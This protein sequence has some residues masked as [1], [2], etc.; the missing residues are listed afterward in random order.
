M[1]SNLLQPNLPYFDKSILIQSFIESKILWSDLKLISPHWSLFTS[2]M[3]S[4]LS[5]CSLWLSIFWLRILLSL[6]FSNQNSSFSSHYFFFTFLQSFCA[7]IRIQEA[8]CTQCKC[9][10]SLS[11]LLLR[12]H[13]IAKRNLQQSQREQFCGGRCGFLKGYPEALMKAFY[14]LVILYFSRTFFALTCPKKH[15]RMWLYL[16]LPAPCCPIFPYFSL[17]VW[18]ILCCQTLCLCVLCMFSW[19]SISLSLALG[20]LKSQINSAPSNG[21]PV[22]RGSQMNHELHRQRHLLRSSWGFA[23]S[24]S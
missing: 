22:V 23:V 4:T 19:N 16:P 17:L 5:L 12:N 8:A 20:I 7:T 14:W 10:Q 15:F 18:K 9:C 13:Y 1:C 21:R 24:I 11:E 3:K 2:L 6:H